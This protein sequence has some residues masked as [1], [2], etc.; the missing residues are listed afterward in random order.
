MELFF[1]PRKDELLWAIP[2]IFQASGLTQ[3]LFL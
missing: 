2:A 1:G 3:K